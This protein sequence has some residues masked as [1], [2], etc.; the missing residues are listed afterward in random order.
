MWVDGVYVKAG[1]DQQTLPRTG[2]DGGPERREQGGGERCSR[3]QGVHRELVPRCSEDIKRR[4]SELDEAGGWTRTSWPSGELSATSIR[5]LAEQ[6]CWNQQ[7][8]RKRARQASKATIRTT[9]SSMLR[10]LSSLTRRL[11]QRLSGSGRCSPGGAATVPTRL[12]QQALG[13]GLGPH[14]SRF[15]DLTPEHSGGTFARSSSGRIDPSR[16]S[17]FGPMPPKRYNRVNRAIAVICKILMVTEQR[18]TAT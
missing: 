15:D 4:G 1:L 7:P 3:I 11:G 18:L 17:G 6:R 2:G 5:R 16:P 9:P 10:G 8:I 12:P 13:A 14:R